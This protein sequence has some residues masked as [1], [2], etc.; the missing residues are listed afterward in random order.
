MKNGFA[1]YVV[2]KAKAHT[3]NRFVVS[4]LPTEE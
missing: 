4:R 2:A 1:A 3:G